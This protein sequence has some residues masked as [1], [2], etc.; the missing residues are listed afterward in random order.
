MA[1]TQ[2]KIKKNMFVNYYRQKGETQ[3]IKPTKLT[4]FQESLNPNVVEANYITDEAASQNL[5]SY[6][7]SHTAPSDL[8]KNEAGFEFFFP[9]YQKLKTGEDAK[10]EHLMVYMFD[11][12]GENVY[13][14]RMAEYTAVVNSLNVAEA[15][16]DIQLQSAGD[17][18]Q[19]YV[20]YTDTIPEFTEGEYS[21]T[22]PAPDTLSE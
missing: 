19:G 3:W 2:I 6:A 11:K 16:I 8:F 22:P 10:V 7:P 12:L 14:A 5:E 21:V 20:T 1:E 18:K 4:D 17:T 13:G 15:K 9:F